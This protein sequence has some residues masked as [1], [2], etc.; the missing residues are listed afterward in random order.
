MLNIV[1]YFD[2]WQFYINIAQ[3][4]RNSLHFLALYIN[5]LSINLLLRSINTRSNKWITSRFLAKYHIITMLWKIRWGIF[6]NH[7]VCHDSL[8]IWHLAEWENNKSRFLAL[9]STWFVNTAL[10]LSL[11]AR[12]LLS[13]KMV[14]ML[15]IPKISIFKMSTLINS[16]VIHN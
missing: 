8:S 3:V 5:M 7:R 6:L 14:L 2:R 4:N 11:V 12:L 9:K 10:H 16:F 13:I 15:V 1:P